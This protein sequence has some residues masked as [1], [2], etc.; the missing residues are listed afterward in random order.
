MKTN[1]IIYG[2]YINKIYRTILTRWRLSNFDLRIETGRY[3]D[4]PRELRLCSLCLRGDIEN[5][6]SCHLHM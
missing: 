1:G 2:N 4:T 5:T 6:A 3:D